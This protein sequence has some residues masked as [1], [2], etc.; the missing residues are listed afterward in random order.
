MSVEELSRV[1]R[2]G[3]GY[4]IDLLTRRGSKAVAEVIVRATR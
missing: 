4:W 1:I 2:T 3:G